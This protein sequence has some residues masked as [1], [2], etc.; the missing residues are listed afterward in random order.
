MGLKVV[1]AD[2]ETIIRLDIRE[3]LQGHG[4]EVVGEASDGFDAINL[5]KTLSPDVILLDIKMP[6]LDGLSAAKVI[7]EENLAPCV[8]LTTA[9][10][11]DAFIQQAKSLGIMGYIVKPIDSKSLIPAIEV[12]VARSREFQSLKRDIEEREKKMEDRKLVEKAKGLLM[13]KRKISEA[14]AY[15]YI[16]ML[17]MNKRV[18]M[19]QIAQLIIMSHQSMP[20][21]P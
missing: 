3:Q 10:S 4:Y 9:Y 12:A 6:I 5:C 15:D 20:D 21:V 7:T 14:D 1:I 8:I 19:G 13:E 18:P 11:D 17:S 2:D 16:R